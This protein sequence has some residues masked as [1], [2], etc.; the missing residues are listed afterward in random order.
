[1]TEDVCI[2]VLSLWKMDVGGRLLF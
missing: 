1:M 2:E